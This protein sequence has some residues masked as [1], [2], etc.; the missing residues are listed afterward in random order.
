[1]RFKVLIFLLLGWPALGAGPA[2]AWSNH[3]LVAYS[4]FRDMKEVASAPPVV[5]ER[6]E[7]FLRTEEPA[8]ADLLAAQEVWARTNIDAYPPRPAELTFK[9]DPARSDEARKSA[10][11]HALRIAANTKFALFV[12]PDPKGPRDPA[13]TLPFSAVSTL[14]EPAFSLMRFE[15]VEPGETISAL[16]ALASSADEPDFGTDINCWDDSPSIWGKLYG[17]GKIPFGNPALDFSTQAPFHMGFYHESWV[18]YRAAPFVARTYPLLRAHQF[19]GL[20]QL[21]FR[22]GHTYWG[23]RFAANA[24]HYV[25]DLAQPYHARLFP[26]MSTARLVLANTLAVLGWPRQKNDLIVLVSNRHLALERYQAQLM[27]R[28]TT[29]DA[30]TPLAA[31]VRSEARDADYPAWSDSYL[32]DVVTTESAAFAD[33]LNDAL[34]RAAPAAYVSDAGFDFGAQGGAIDLYAELDRLDAPA[35]SELDGLIAEL[36]G[37]FGAHSRNLVRAALASAGPAGAR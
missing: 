25:E 28:A 31:A 12:Q 16:T 29:Q 14:R 17:F 24:M 32:R 26:G 1:M 9:S 7:D 37:H 18:I 2:R 27:F 23:W 8:V 19:F 21:A 15:R 13:R 6:L 30:A 10:F 22:T 3:G 33:R 20:S 11:V 35:R 34:L 4:V 36:L 5:V